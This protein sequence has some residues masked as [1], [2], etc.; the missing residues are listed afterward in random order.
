MP[1]SSAALP[2]LLSGNLKS[3]VRGQPKKDGAGGKFTMG[4]AVDQ[5]GLAVLDEKGP[6]Y[7]SDSE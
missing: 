4:R 6:N 5:S 3:S 7:D 1:H 2:G